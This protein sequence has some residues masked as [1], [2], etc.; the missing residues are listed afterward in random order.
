M[1]NYQI[2]MEL[3]S[4]TILGSGESVAGYIDLDV[5][6]D[7]LGLPYFKGKTLKGRLREEAENIVRLQSDVFTQEQ[8]NKLFG[9]IDNEQDTSLALS[10][11]TVSNNIRKAIKASNLSSN[12]IL[13]SLTDVRSFTAIDKD[14]IAKE[15]SLRQIRVINK[16]LKI[17]SEVKFRNEIDNDEL[18]LFGLSVLALRHIGLMC[19]RGKGNVKCTLLKNGQ[20]ITNTIIDNLR[21]KVK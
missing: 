11:C 19:S 18:T 1:D 9:K 5:L 3:L 16:G 2:K 21:E 20:D 4:E 13:N 8:L 12:D 10:D 7:E 15:G 6:H 14:G 17:N